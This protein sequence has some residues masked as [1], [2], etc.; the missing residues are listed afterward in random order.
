[1][2]TAHIEDIEGGARETAHLGEGG[3]ALETVPIAG[4]G[5]AHTGGGA[6]RPEGVAGSDGGVR[7][8][9]MEN[10]DI[11]EQ[12]PTQKHVTV[13]ECEGTRTLI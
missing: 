2:G 11:V 7:P 1:M 5:G 9:H 3:G 8:A 6:P 4:E 10:K 12:R 13:G